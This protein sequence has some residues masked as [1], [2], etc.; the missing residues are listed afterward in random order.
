MGYCTTLDVIALNPSRTPGAGTNPSTDQIQTYIDLSSSEIDAI[1]VNKGY[2]TPISNTY[3]GAYALLRSINAKGAVAF[4]ERGAP[5]SPNLD[6]FEKEWEQSLEMLRA[7]QQVMDAPKDVLRAQPRGPGVTSPPLI[8]F[9][10]EPY[11][12]R[13]MHF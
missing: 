5:T 11:F 7:A 13:H 9:G 10:N 4:M 3:S 1:L 8:A 12:R 6:R 2:E